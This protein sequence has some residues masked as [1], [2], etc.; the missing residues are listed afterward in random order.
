MAVA[1]DVYS[2]WVEA[3]PLQ[4]KHAF[5]AAGWFYNEVLARWGRPTFIRCDHGTEW[6]AEFRQQCQHI[7]IT[8]RKGAVGNSRA[9]G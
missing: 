8:I 2:K 6:Q 7:E 9:N 5:L 1:V 4:T 3:Y